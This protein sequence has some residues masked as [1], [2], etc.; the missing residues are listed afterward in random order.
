MNFDLTDEQT[1]L[2]STVRRFID[3]SYSFERRR[4]IQ[5]SADGFSRAHWSQFADLGLL[6][7]PFSEDDGGVG[8]NAVDMAIVMSELGRGLVL[9]PFLSTVV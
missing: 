7:I 6:A 2:Q 5:A 3:T 8:G 4:Q 1:M 9:E